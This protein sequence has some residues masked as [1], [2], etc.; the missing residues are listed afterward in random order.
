[1][2]K[3]AMQTLAAAAGFIAIVGLMWSWLVTVQEVLL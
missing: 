2:F 1:M 3:L